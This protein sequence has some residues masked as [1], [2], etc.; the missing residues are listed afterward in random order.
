MG[1]HSCVADAWIREAEEASKLLQQMESKLDNHHN[2]ETIQWKLFELGPKIGRLES[3]LRNPP[4][5][6]ILSDQDLEQRQKMLT[7]IQLQ[8]RAV[9]LRLLPS[10]VTKSPGDLPTPEK[11]TTITV[12]SSDQ[13]H[14]KATVCSEEEELSTP[15]VG[16]HSVGISIKKW[17]WKA[18]LISFL[19]L[20]AAALLV[21]LYIVC[22]LIRPN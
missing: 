10:Q 5:I 15:L 18:C 19:A 14:L 11:G 9:A 2:H 17:I 13:D 21:V 8:T 7:E 20:V 3:L 16:M 1:R 4:T 22:A 6:P 12:S